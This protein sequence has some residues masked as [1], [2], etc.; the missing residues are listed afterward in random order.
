MKKSFW[1]NLVLGAIVLV[2]IQTVVDD[3]ATLTDWP[4]NVRRILLYLG[5]FFDLFFTIEFLVRSYLA[6]V[7]GRVKTYLFQ[8]YGWI[9]FLASIPLLLFSSGPVIYGLLAGG[10][11]VFGLGRSLNL[12][13]TIKIIRIARILRVL[14]MLKLVKQ[15]KQTDSVMAQRH[16]GKI[17][18]SVLTTCILVFSAGS[19]LIESVSGQSFERM[20]WESLESASQTL[21]AVP[22]AEL[23]AEARKVAGI[24]PPLLKVRRE[25]KD[26]F[27]RYDPRYLSSMFG[28]YD[29][30]YV[31]RSSIELYF[32]YRPLNRFQAGQSLL[33]FTMILGILLVLLLYYAPHFAIT[34]T[35][36]LFVMLKG[37][38]DPSYNLEVQVPPRLKDDEVFRLAEQFN[39]QYLPLKQ[40][41][42]SE[43]ETAGI[44]WEAVSELFRKG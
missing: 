10:I 11:P 5:F 15:L 27:L 22:P 36:P 7:E 32:D 14:R 24:L 44:Q 38:Q 30:L 41:K 34:V 17:A 6:Y 16:M 12:L 19:I 28:P 1:E 29:Y 23:S 8:G 20:Y 31:Q 37:F 18:T 39:E 43:G 3:V 9:D 21:S 25:G 42:L 33:I 35:D 4:W 2:L 40:R 26:L 13:K